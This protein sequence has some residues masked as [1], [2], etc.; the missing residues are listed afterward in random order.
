M[1]TTSSPSPR[2]AKGHPPSANPLRTQP[3]PHLSQPAHRRVVST[4]SISS[5]ETNDPITR[6]LGRRPS[7]S[8]APSPPLELAPELSL[9]VKSPAHRTVSN[10]SRVSADAHPLGGDTAT[11]HS[12]GTS[13]P[14]PLPQR[15]PWPDTVATPTSLS[16]AGPQATRQVSPRTQAHKF[17]SEEVRRFCQ[18][19]Q[20]AYP[21]LQEHPEEWQAILE[22]VDRF[23]VSFLR[24]ATTALQS[25]SPEKRS[26]NTVEPEPSTPRSSRELDAEVVAEHYQLFLCNLYTALESA[27]RG[28]LSGS[29]TDATRQLD[30]A[31][32]PDTV[33]MG[34]LSEIEDL[35]TRTLY[36]HMFCPR[37]H[38]TNCDDHLQDEATASRIAALNLADLK[39]SHLGLDLAASPLSDPQYQ[40]RTTSLRIHQDATG[41]KLVDSPASWDRHL[42]YVAFIEEAI[43]QTAIHLQALDQAK[44]VIQK[45]ECI[46]GAHRVLTKAAQARPVR[47]DSSAKTGN[48]SADQVSSDKS[49]ASEGPQDMTKVNLPTLSA[50]D[51]LPL[52][53]YTVIKYNPPR[54]VS[55]VRYIQRYLYRERQTSGVPAYCLTTLVAAVTFLDTVDFAALGLGTHQLELLPMD[56]THGDRNSLATVTALSPVAPGEPA[57][58]NRQTDPENS[59]LFS[60]VV[61]GAVHAVQRNLPKAWSHAI[62][63]VSP[64][65]SNQPTEAVDHTENKANILNFTFSPVISRQNTSEGEVRSKELVPVHHSTTDLDDPSTNSKTHPAGSSWIPDS[66]SPQTFF[67]PSGRTSSEVAEREPTLAPPTARVPAS[68][69]LA[70]AESPTSPALSSNMAQRMGK[71]LQNVT[72][73][74]IKVLS[75]VYG[76][77]FNKFINQ[78]TAPELDGKPTAPTFPKNELD[79][80]SL[81]ETKP[82]EAQTA[83]GGPKEPGSP[84][85]R[86]SEP[87]LIRRRTEPPRRPTKLRDSMVVQPTA[88][89]DKDSSLKLAPT[90]ALTQHAIV[91]DKV[92]EEQGPIRPENQQDTPWQSLL[93]DPNPTFVQCQAK[94]LTIGQVEELLVDYQRLATALATLKQSGQTQP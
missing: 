26:G 35:C 17:H 53:I 30:Q 33:M 60:K 58:H 64:V 92:I 75:G 85:G 8:T 25:N 27:Y 83:F 62:A 82:G 7:R 63:A 38:Y 87:H 93:P 81:E 31:S 73:G 20:E 78:E 79:R 48:Q 11:Q 76:M 88:R 72:G 15:R 90:T 94:D 67:N 49:E 89:V 36:S 39:L 43:R 71:E 22:D 2:L 70:N 59:R 10:T 77:V 69:S 40:F 44:S 86:F 54:L 42:G 1:S 6:S 56:D 28:L 3:S 55:N 80:Q 68:V 91:S 32:D 41:D 19:S 57:K 21:L 37:Y 47:V 24:R 16:P 61:G 4:S 46:V 5:M 14:P 9:G 23:I 65:P 52:L 66:L 34:W 29:S 51:L 50:D 45:M 18:V 13:P 12:P 84:S 74:G